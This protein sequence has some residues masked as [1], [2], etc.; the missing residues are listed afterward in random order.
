MSKGQGVVPGGGN[1]R[2]EL[3]NMS[4]TRFML[5]AVVAGACALA[6][7]AISVPAD[8]ST[9]TVTG[10]QVCFS[11]TKVHLVGRGLTRDTNGTDY[12]AFAGTTAVANNVHIVSGDF[13]AV[14]AGPDVFIP[15]K[16]Y[17]WGLSGV[18][19][20]VDDAGSFVMKSASC[21]RFSSPSVHR[22]A[23]DRAQVAGFRSGERVRISIGRTVLKTVI[24]SSSGKATGTFIVPRSLSRGWHRAVARGLRSGRTA[25]AFLRVLAG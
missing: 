17:T 6:T 20:M 21:L 7:S 11:P 2:R 3:R 15:G 4:R 19:E 16:T 22:G 14:A 12:Q 23:R 25:V 9:G 5:A 24:A 8:A 18:K 13:S 1:S 10:T